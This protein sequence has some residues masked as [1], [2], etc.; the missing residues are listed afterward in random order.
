MQLARHNEKWT[1]EE[2]LFLEIFYPVEFPVY[3]SDVMEMYNLRERLGNN[4][5]IN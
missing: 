3:L 4:V 2:N 1:E 5:Y